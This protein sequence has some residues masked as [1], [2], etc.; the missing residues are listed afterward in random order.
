MAQH[1]AVLCLAL[2]VQ[3]LRAVQA[4]RFDPGLLQGADMFLCRKNYKRHT[5]LQGENYEIT[6]KKDSGEERNKTHFEIVSGRK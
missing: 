3:A 6:K 2:G 4:Y 1:K 5:H